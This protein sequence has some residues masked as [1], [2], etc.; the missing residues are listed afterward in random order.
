MSTTHV[1]TVLT[2]YSR[3]QNMPR[4]IRAWREQ[5]VPSR[6]VVV[7]NTPP[8]TER[9]ERPTST[10]AYPREEVQ[11]A[12]D[13]WRMTINHGCPCDFGAALQVCHEFRYIMFADDDFVPGKRAL[14]NLLSLATS[15]RVGNNFAT[16]GEQTGA[17]MFLLDRP[18]GKRYKGNSVPHVSP[19]MAAPCHLTCRAH[20]VC[21][22]LLYHVIPFRHMFKQYGDEGLRLVNKHDDF[23]LSLG[24]QMGTGYPSYCMRTARE[25]DY[26]DK[27]FA[28]NIEENNPLWKRPGHF[29]ERARMVDLSLALG[30]KPLT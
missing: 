1:L 2:N 25:I 15:P 8:P 18:E 11:G 4:V 7:D 19:G 28:Q 24:I 5:T 20:L 16:I 6:I 12:D 26:D 10:E 13:V 14:Q 9:K 17:R 3:P 29:E 30:W 27:L 23:L 21:A 22:D